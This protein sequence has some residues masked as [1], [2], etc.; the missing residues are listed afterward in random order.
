MVLTKRTK[1][2]I[3][4]GSILIGI[5]LIVMGIVSVVFGD[6]IT[7]FV[8]KKIN[9]NLNTN[10]SVKSAE[11]SIFKRFPNA[12]VIFNDV[13]IKPNKDFV[14]D[15][16]KNLERDLIKCRHIYV[17]INI[18]KLLF[19][20]YTIQRIV[21]E[22]GELFLETNKAGVLSFDI[23][24]KTGDDGKSVTSVDLKNIILKR[25]GYH[26]LDHRNNVMLEG[27]ARKFDV[28]G[29]IRGDVFN[30]DMSGDLFSKSALIQDVEY[31]GNRNLETSFELKR[32]GD[33]YR[34]ETSSLNVEGIEMNLKMVFSTDDKSEIDLLAEATNVSL[35]GFQKLIPDEYQKYV[36]N[37]KSKGKT[38]FILSVKGK[39]YGNSLPHVDFSFAIKNG[40]IAQTLSN[41]KLSDVNC[42]GSYSNG[43][44][45]NSETSQVLINDFSSS[46]GA[47]QISGNFSYRNFNQPDINLDLK[48]FIDLA[49]FRK[50]LSLDTIENM[51]GKLRGDLKLAVGFK[52]AE[53][54]EKGNIR[55]CKIEGG[56]KISDGQFKL[57]NSNYLFNNISSEII[58]G[59]DFQFE[60]LSLKIDNND[61]FISGRLYDAVPYLL[62]QTKTLNL[63]AEL[64]SQNLDLSKYFEKANQ[65]ASNSKYNSRLLF[66]EDLLAELNVSV[67]H[68]TLSKFQATNVIARVNY[69]PGM[70]TLNSVV[71]E[72]MQGKVSGNGAV[73]LDAGENLI[74]RGQTSIKKLDI[75]RLFY[76][77]A[78]FGQDILEDKHLK[79]FVTG[80]IMF[81][82]EW[83]NNMVLNQDAV[84]VE[85]TIE[86]NNGELINFEPLTGLSNFVALKELK[87]IKFSTLRNQVFIR[88]KQIILPNMDINSSALNIS[89]SGIH[90]FDNHYTY[91]INVL[92]S[93]VLARKA[94]QNKKENEE[95]GVVEDDG[96]GRTRIPLLIEGFNNDYKITYD[97]KGVK[98]IVK[99]SLQKQKKELKAIFKEEFG[100]Y[101]NDSTVTKAKTGTK[102][103]IEW[104]EKSLENKEPEKTTK[105]KKK[106]FEEEEGFQVEFEK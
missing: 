48:T 34:M 3:V 68:F 57:K 80:D 25:I 2:I 53:N 16:A 64:R 77:F 11:F 14:P 23:F 65:T 71:F 29:S 92:L 26:Y 39:T 1:K 45:N 59:N 41:I 58:L 99:E 50:F 24:K 43:I 79:G 47:G 10:V 83:D 31:F 32:E 33:V 88:H 22:D 13:A 102:Y 104:D 51:E 84:L 96:L 5:C 42:S 20:N 100:L 44:R 36:Q 74:V 40:T 76:S 82:C 55:S 15:N 67:S 30:F 94:R 17:D 95:F 60:N 54:F 73:I 75:K 87:D 93:E 61:F 62:N 98:E 97:T 69:K 9:E 19:K 18:I 52:N 78:N 90:N 27:I 85:S 103:K 56:L 91:R 7:A 49:V 89:G 86:I 106:T 72:T 8:I 70:Y 35:A 6:S 63:K 101:K 28:K 37:F 38:N 66:P 21:V 12:A 81:A 4:I 46:L 105:K